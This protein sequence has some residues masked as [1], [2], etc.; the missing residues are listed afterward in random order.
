VRT[1]RT[2]PLGVLQRVAPLRRLNTDV[3]GTLLPDAAETL[4]RVC[5]EH[6]RG[7]DPS[8][9]TALTSTSAA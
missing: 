9:V 8:D 1:H 7:T 6:G 4:K 3:I 5:Q 2:S